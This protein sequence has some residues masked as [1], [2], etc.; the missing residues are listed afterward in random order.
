M[1]SGFFGKLQ[2]AARLMEYPN[3]LAIHKHGSVDL[4][5]EMNKTWWQVHNIQTIMDIGANT[6]KYAYTMS[7]VFPEAQI[8]SFE[9]LPECYHELC[10]RMANVKRFTAYNIGLGSKS[11]TSTFFRNKYSSAS[12]FLPMTQVHKQAFPQT[13]EAFSEQSRIVRLDDIAHELVIKEPLLVKIDVQGY[14]MQVLE[15]GMSVI[16]KASI[17]ILETSFEAL[18]EDQSLFHDLY[19]YLES[20]GFHFSGIIEQ[21]RGGD[22]RI[23]QADSIFLSSSILDYE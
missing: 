3:L 9:P 6:G 18:Y 14:E 8:Y 21:H 1:I 10:R 23:L 5:L 19:L 2:R 4:Y 15:G 12:S 13:K 11:G 22:G 17:I 20:W 7:E 16:Q